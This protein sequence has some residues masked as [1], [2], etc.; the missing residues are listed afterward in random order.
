MPPLLHHLQYSTKQAGIPFKRS[1]FTCQL[2][3]VLDALPSVGQ[4]PRQDAST[5]RVGSNNACVSPAHAPSSHKIHDI[6]YEIH[7]KKCSRQEHSHRECDIVN[8]RIPSPTM[9]DAADTRAT[10]SIGTPITNL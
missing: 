10:D 5:I 8:P 9:A 6:C 4:V 3:R 1:V 2:Q 7:A